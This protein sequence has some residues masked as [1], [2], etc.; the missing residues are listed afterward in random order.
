MALELFGVDSNRGMAFNL[1]NLRAGGSLLPA[2]IQD[3]EQK[4]RSSQQQQ[5]KDRKPRLRAIICHHA[6]TSTGLISA[7]PLDQHSKGELIRLA[8]QYDVAAILTGHTH[9][10]EARDYV[11]RTGHRTWELRSASTVQMDPQPEPQ[12]F[13]VHVLECNAGQRRWLAYRYQ[14]NAQKSG[15]TRWQYPLTVS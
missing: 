13:W 8:H 15:F 14:L 2:D 12:G 1:T 7:Q 11:D 10:F 9:D 4:L 5:Q 6:F 3:L